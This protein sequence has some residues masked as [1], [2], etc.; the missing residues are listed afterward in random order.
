MDNVFVEKEI[1]C[2]W[3]GVFSGRELDMN[4]LSTE[5]GYSDL[6]EKCS[7]IFVKDIMRTRPVTIKG[8]DSVE[9]VL[10]VFNENQ[11]HT[12]P[13]VE[14]NGSFLG[15]I[16]QNIILQLLLTH[17]VSRL[18]HT[19]LM[20]VKSLSESARGIMIPHPVTIPPEMDLCEVAEIMLKHKVDRFCVVDNDKLVGII[21]KPDVIKAIYSIRG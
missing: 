5:E 3:I 12:Y 13:V 9:R 15:I 16:D 14:K 7:R 6:D 8:D 20:A 17:R 1:Y 21:C 18:D 11:F 2:H 10:E 19:H 4:R